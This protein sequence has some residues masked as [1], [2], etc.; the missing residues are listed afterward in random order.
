MTSDCVSLLINT[1]YIKKN[2]INKTELYYFSCLSLQP[3]YDRGGAVPVSQCHVHSPG[4]S[5]WLLP[6]LALLW[7]FPPSQ[8]GV[9]T[10]RSLR[11]SPPSEV[12]AARGW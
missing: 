6:P 1:Q 2:H 9:C 8:R 5:S 11:T 10:R 12:R 4:S 3:K 7:G